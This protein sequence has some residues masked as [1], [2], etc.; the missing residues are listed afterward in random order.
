DAVAEVHAGCLARN[1]TLEV[2]R[3]TADLRE[4]FASTGLT[5]VIGTDHF[6]PTVVAAVAAA[7]A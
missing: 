1:I 5:D 6:H 3:A 7:T 2:A 4:H